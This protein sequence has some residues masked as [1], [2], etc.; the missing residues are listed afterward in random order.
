MG[1][2]VQ[3]TIIQTTDPECKLLHEEIFG[4]VLT[5]YVFEDAD[6]DETVK[7][8]DR[9]SPYGLTGSIFCRDR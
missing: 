9:T 6:W 5:V 8:V 2:Y 7:L 1:Y 4:P 3:P